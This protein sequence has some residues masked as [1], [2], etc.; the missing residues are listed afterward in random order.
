[1][2]VPCYR[3]ARKFLPYSLSICDFRGTVD[4]TAEETFI[5]MDNQG[6]YEVRIGRKDLDLNV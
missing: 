4:K 5:L 6:V 2:S 1:M 3:N